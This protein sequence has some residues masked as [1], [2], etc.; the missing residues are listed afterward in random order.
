MISVKTTL[1]NIPLYATHLLNFEQHSVL[2]FQS[3]YALNIYS[4]SLLE[5]NTVF[6]PKS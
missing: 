2:I 4:F 6:N 3:L 1:A 5:K